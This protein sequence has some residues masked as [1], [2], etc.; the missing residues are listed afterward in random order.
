MTGRLA[1]GDSP[2]AARRAGAAVKA[3]GFDFAFRPQP[4][5]HRRPL[6]AGARRHPA[7][8]RN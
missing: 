8:V 4:T 7:V 6:L 2:K 5:L 3:V 1:A